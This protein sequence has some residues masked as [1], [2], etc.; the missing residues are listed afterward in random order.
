MKTRCL[1]IAFLLAGCGSNAKS[2]ISDAGVDAS[3]SCLLTTAPSEIRLLMGARRLLER[4]MLT[5]DEAAVFSSDGAI[6]VFD[7]PDDSTEIVVRATY[8]E[9]AAALRVT[10]SDSSSGTVPVVVTPIAFHNL[11]TWTGSAGPIGREYFS[12]WQDA[13]APG[14]L[15]L[16]GGFVYEPT[17]FTP[18]SELWSFDVESAQWTA[19][20]ILDGAPTTPGGRVARGP[21]TNSVF[22]FGG[23]AGMDTPPVL[24]QIDLGTNPP[25]FSQTPDAADSPGSYTGA[26]I[27][28]ERR[29]RWLSLCGASATFGINCTVNAYT[30]ADG[31]TELSV[32]SGPRAPGRMGFAY[33]YDEPND[34]VIVFAG[35][36][37]AGNLDIGEDT[38]AL[39][40]SESPL[41][42]TRLFE[43]D[44]A[45]TKRRNAGFA[46]DSD[47]ERMFVWGGT[48]DGENSV[49]GMQVLHLDRGHEEWFTF[50]T[51]AEM[52][53]RTS[54]AGIYDASTR[55]VFW[56]FGNDAMVY[57]DVW[58]MS[59]GGASSEA[60]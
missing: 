24:T 6:R 2:M 30:V 44:P 60:L 54:S 53:P 48:P 10:C 55:S 1:A 58:Q 19:H 12:W 31:W 51:P 7:A 32:A 18:N 14:T 35:H 52:V 46:Y 34:R 25:Q 8:E 13:S 20:G 33:A 27:R 57:R 3:P 17:Q 56:G 39:S 9:G 38:W 5:G 49:S 11:A 40:L 21:T 45:A 50:E 23:I 59:L 43:S 41:R 15:W 26:L 16:F 37:G 42:W 36:Q 29:N 22:Y 47:E 4:S 28:D